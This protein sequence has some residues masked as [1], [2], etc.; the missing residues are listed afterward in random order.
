MKT[1]TITEENAEKAYRQ[2]PEAFKE[3][4]KVLLGGKIRRD[5]FEYKSYEDLCAG[6]GIDP[7]KSLPFPSPKTLKEVSC[8]GD[9]KLKTIYEEFNRNDDGTLWKP[10]YS[11]ENE[12]KWYSW[13]DWSPA[14]GCFVLDGTFYADTHTGLGARL[15]AKT[16]QIELYIQKTFRKEINESFNPQL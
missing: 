7:V 14:S 16:E 5:P 13:Q 12:R 2:A 4:L 11:D 6:I 9:F 8:N 10:D 1:I 3:T 15:C